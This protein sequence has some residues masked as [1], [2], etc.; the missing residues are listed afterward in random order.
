MDKKYAQQLLDKT[1]EDYNLIAKDFSRTRDYIPGDILL[2]AK[3]A[4]KGDRIIDLGCGN[5]RLAEAL[6]KSEVEYVGLD[7]SEKL[8]EIAKEKY[9]DKEFLTS[10]ILTLT[11]PDDN[12]DKAFSLAV[13][14]HIP[15]DEFRLRALSEIKRV[16]KPGGILVLTVWNL[17]PI[18]SFLIGKKER[19]FSF[20]NF[21]IKKI[22]GISKLDFKDFFISWNKDCQRY[23]HYFTK[24]DLENLVKKTGFRIKESGFLPRPGGKESNLYLIAQK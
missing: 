5:G 10:S 21:S 24:K 16:L 7:N 23:V 13:F 9:P 3:Y 15:S 6:G 18:E 22:L 2:L 1:K 19:A 4:A 8:I 17:N 11:F 12:F 20:L 14:H